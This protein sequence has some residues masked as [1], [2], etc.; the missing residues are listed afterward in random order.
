VVFYFTTLER[1]GQDFLE[2]RN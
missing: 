1:I 2:W